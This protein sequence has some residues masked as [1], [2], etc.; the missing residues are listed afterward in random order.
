MGVANAL[1]DVDTAVAG[2]I[3]VAVAAAAAAA[4]AAVA[5][6]A[7]L[8]HTEAAACGILGGDTAGGVLEESQPPTCRRGPCRKSVAVYSRR[9][10]SGSPGPRALGGTAR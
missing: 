2:G 9:R 6:A 8:P 4:A 1:V 3:A 7:A 5:V 10:N